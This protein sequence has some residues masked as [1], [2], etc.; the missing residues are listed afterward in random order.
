VTLPSL[1]FSQS[2]DI[3]EAS[4][5][6]ESCGNQHQ[7][8]PYFT[9][10]SGSIIPHRNEIWEFIDESGI[11]RDTLQDKTAPI[12]QFIEVSFFEDDNGGKGKS[13]LGLKLR[14]MQSCWFLL[15]RCFVCVRDQGIRTLETRLFHRFGDGFVY[16]D[17]QERRAQWDDL[18]ALGITADL[19]LLRDPNLYVQLLPQFGAGQST[20]CQVNRP[21]PPTEIS[22][23]ASE[24]ALVRQVE[25][26]FSDSNLPGDVFL[27][28]HLREGGDNMVQLDVVAKFNKMKKL[29]NKLKDSQKSPSFLPELLRSS[30]LL[31]VSDDGN[32]CV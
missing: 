27:Q 7:Q 24:Q 25:F 3:I 18:E 23:N 30:E 5:A 1:D 10:W 16:R 2:T 28:K 6:I 8:W 26:Y 31:L 19:E 20:R 32:R 9:D 11:D 12:L 21:S 13:S 14:V 4:R 29:L 22:A 15:L 17:V